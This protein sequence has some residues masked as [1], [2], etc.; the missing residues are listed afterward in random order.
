MASDKG[1]EVGSKIQHIKQ[2]PDCIKR[3]HLHPVIQ[4][5][6]HDEIYK[7]EKIGKHCNDITESHPFDPMSL[8]LIII[9]LKLLD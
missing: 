2:I 1:K 9:V 8:I 3:S 7:E 4:E 5:Q 6:I